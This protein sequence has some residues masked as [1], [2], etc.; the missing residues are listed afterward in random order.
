MSEVQV[1]MPV[2]VEEPVQKKSFFGRLLKWGAILVE[3][4]VVVNFFSG[5]R[6]DQKEKFAS[7]TRANA[8]QRC[9]ADAAC[10][11]T[12]KTKFAQ[13]LEE[14]SDSHKSGK[15]NRKYTLDEPGFYSCVR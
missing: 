2:P 4:W 6:S 11:A 13:C 5:L 15:Y 9:Q 1:P 10:L 12:L 8:E 7:T 14:H 3:L